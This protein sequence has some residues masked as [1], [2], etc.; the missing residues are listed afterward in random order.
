[1]HVVPSEVVYHPKYPYIWT[2][3]AARFPEALQTDLDEA[4]GLCAIA[5][6]FLTN[7]GMT[8]PGELA[9]VIG[10]KR[11]IVGLANQALVK[12]GFANS[13]S[14]GTYELADAS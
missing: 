5:R 12:E 2:L 13:P 7:A 10:A 9:R 6:C 8:Y 14:S 4:A 3:T 11:P 1:M